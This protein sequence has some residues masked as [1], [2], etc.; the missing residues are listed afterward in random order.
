MIR[1]MQR[2]GIALF[3]MCILPSNVSAQSYPTKPL[4]FIFGFSPGTIL[5]STARPVADEMAKSLGQPIVFEFKPGASGTIAAKYV[6]GSAPDGYTFFYNTVTT[7][8]PALVKNNAAS[9]ALTA[10]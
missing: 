3:A 7:N 5:D 2:I 6:A 4:H 10:R 8:D 1:S 9:A